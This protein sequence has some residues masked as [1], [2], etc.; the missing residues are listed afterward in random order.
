MFNR[1]LQPAIKEKMISIIYLDCNM[2]IAY[3]LE[4]NN[5]FFYQYLVNDWWIFG[6]HMIKLTSII[7][8]G[9]RGTRLEPLTKM[10][11]KPAVPIAG[12][13]RLIDIPISNCLHAGIAHIFVLTQFNTE[14]LHRHI[15]RTYIFDSFS[16]GYIRILAAQQTADNQ[17]WYQGTADAVRK[18]MHFM[19]NVDDYIIILSGD[20]LYR[21]DYRKFF[22]YHL[23]TG[24]DISIS[25]KPI[26][27][28]EVKLFG[29]LKA[30][31]E[32]KI[33]DF[34]EKPKDKA[35]IDDY[36]IDPALFKSFE[37]EPQ[38]RSHIASM[39]IYIF[40]KKVLFDL[41]ADNSLED[42]GREIIPKSIREL[43][44]YAYFYDGYWKDIGNIS[45]FFEAHMDLTQPIPKFNFYDEQYPF[46]T[47]RRYLPASKVH[48]CHVNQ[49]IIAEGSILLGSVIEQSVVGIRAFIDE[50]TLVQSSI[51]MG[52]TR[53]ETVENK[54]NNRG[55]GNPNLGIGKNCVIKRAIIDLDVS[56]ADNVQLI[57]KENVTEAFRDAYA[58]RD[59]II[60]IPKGA[61]LPEYTVI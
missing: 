19:E 36:Q 53:Y 31:S 22:D 14:S 2:I 12:K 37:I 38:N 47:R 1:H 57:N 56:I 40:N 43:N 8:G 4:K 34:I 55:L 48:N 59:G 23:R 32:G 42:F 29:I 25:V 6:V 30:D 49:S 60:I 13:F 7:L 45:S 9:G 5:E 28:H 17:D 26:Y 16:K 21:M 3:K 20:H 39:G 54:R 10:R 33:T 46:Y 44:V 52:N 50:G 15:H 41:L 11:A 24:A 61:V 18:N 27:E 58:I 35:V 51:I